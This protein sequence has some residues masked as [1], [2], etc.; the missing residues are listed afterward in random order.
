[1]EVINYKCES[2]K[3]QI[4]STLL[5]FVSQDERKYYDATLWDELALNVNIDVITHFSDSNFLL[6]IE[7][8]AEQTINLG[9]FHL[10]PILFLGHG[11]N[12]ILRITDD[13][14]GHQYINASQFKKMLKNIAHMGIKK[15]VFFL[16]VCNIQDIFWNFCK[17]FEEDFPN[18]IDVTLH[19]YVTHTGRLDGIAQLKSLKSENRFLKNFPKLYNS[20][21]PKW[22]IITWE[23]E[24]HITNG[25]RPIYSRRKIRRVNYSNISFFVF[26]V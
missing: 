13:K 1:M 15:C 22:D 12:G 21:C 24:L 5:A 11:E 9:C 20:Q 18:T 14:S 4:L 26:V 6:L 23:Q 25:G 19:G 17:D 8:F 16:H 2:S 3:S 10:P 7:Y